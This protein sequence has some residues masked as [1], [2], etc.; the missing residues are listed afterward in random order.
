MTVLVRDMMV[1]DAEM[2]AAWINQPRVGKYLSSNLRHG[3]MQA[4]LIRAALRRSDQ[5]WSV[6]LIDGEAVGLVAFDGIDAEDGIANCW[7][8]LGEERFQGQ[9]ASAQALGLVLEEKRDALHSVT[10]WTAA[11]NTA[12]IRCLEKVG[13]RRVGA[14]SG[15]FVIDGER[16]DRILF[17]RVLN[18]N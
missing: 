1:E 4:G 16:T 13:F 11:V 5:H 2:V 10:A 7:Y 9:G 17:E 18:P 6:F 15:A 3:D 8:L 14:Y 12:S